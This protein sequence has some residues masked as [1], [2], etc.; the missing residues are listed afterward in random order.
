MIWLSVV[1]KCVIVLGLLLAYWS[2]SARVWKEP[3]KTITRLAALA[4]TGAWLAAWLAPDLIVLGV[5]K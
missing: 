4:L 5:L 2:S 3:T 1:I